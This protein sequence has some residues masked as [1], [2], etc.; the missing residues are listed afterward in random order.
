MRM[1]LALL[2]LISCADGTPTEVRPQP[3]AESVWGDEQNTLTILPNGGR[4]EGLCL[5]GAI[6]NVIVVDARGRFDANGTLRRAGGPPRE[7]DAPESVRYAGVI[8]GDTMSLT[9]RR[10]DNSTVLE[11]TLKRGIRGAARPCA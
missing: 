4:F 3:L 9:I 1:L 8:S 7:D 5:A 2:L 11:A 10:A 6:D